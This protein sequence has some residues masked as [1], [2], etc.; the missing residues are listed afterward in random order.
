MIS[1]SYNG[2]TDWPEEEREAMDAFEAA[3]ALPARAPIT[4]ILLLP[5]VQPARKAA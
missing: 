1:C 3:Q 4:R 2:W 5:R